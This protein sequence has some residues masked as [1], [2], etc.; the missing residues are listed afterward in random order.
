MI[1][2]GG[3]LLEGL[4]NVGVLTRE[5]ICHM[6]SIVLIQTNIKLNGIIDH[7]AA[8]QFFSISHPPCTPER[9]RQRRGANFFCIPR[10]KF[11]FSRYAFRASYV[12]DRKHVLTLIHLYMH[13]RNLFDA[14]YI[15]AK[16]FTGECS[17]MAKWRKTFIHDGFVG[18][19]LIRAITVE[20][21]PKCFYLVIRFIQFD[22]AGCFGKPSP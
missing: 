13:R 2:S 17:N 9:T 11:I 8:R 16:Y 20:C 4:L 1:S 10:V 14:G 19:F 5:R 7:F 21:S 12:Q 15:W 22:I 6:I 3:K 18:F